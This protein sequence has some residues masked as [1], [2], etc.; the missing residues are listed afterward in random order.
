MAA[1]TKKLGSIVDV[2]EG[3]T[4]VRPDGTEVTV[5]GGGYVLD[6]PGVYLI[7]GQEVTAK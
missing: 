4:V 7:D 1:N 2:P 3:K 5:S 6:V